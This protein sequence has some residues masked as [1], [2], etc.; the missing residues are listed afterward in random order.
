MIEG[1][2]PEFC[3]KVCVN[4]QCKD[5]LCKSAMSLF[6]WAVL[7]GVISSSWEDVVTF[8]VEKISYFWVVE[9]LTTLVKINILAVAWRVILCKEVCA[10]L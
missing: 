10:P 1:V 3:V 6:Y 4:K 8:L 7:V 9:E 5:S 2:W